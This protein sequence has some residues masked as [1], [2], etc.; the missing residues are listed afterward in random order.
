METSFSELLKRAHEFNR[1]KLKV[2][3]QVRSF[4]YIGETYTNLGKSH[5]IP[6]KPTATTETSALA[7]QDILTPKELAARLKVSVGWIK[8][9]RRPRCKNPIPALPIG[10]ELRFDWQ[11]IQKWLAEQAAIDAASIAAR[12]GKRAQRARLRLISK[13]RKAAA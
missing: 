9:K 5:G 10:G 2:N 13:P 4:Q 1:D 8:E 6:E 3:S 7:F 11:A 12:Q